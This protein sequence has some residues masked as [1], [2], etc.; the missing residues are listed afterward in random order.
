MASSATTL[1]DLSYTT[2]YPAAYNTQDN[3]AYYEQDSVILENQNSEFSCDDSFVVN[4][5]IPP[6]QQIY[7][8]LDHV[9]ANLPRDLYIERL[10]T[11]T[12]SD[13]ELVLWYRRILAD[14]ARQLDNCPRGELKG[15]K[16]TT[17][18][19]S[20]HKFATDCYILSTFI[21]GDSSEIEMVFAPS[22]LKKQN[23]TASETEMHKSATMQNDMVVMKSTLHTTITRISNLETNYNKLKR[24]IDERDK[25]LKEVLQQNQSLE[26]SIETLQN[27]KTEIENRIKILEQDI[28][29]QNKKVALNTERI[30]TL[31]QSQEKL[32]TEQSAK[33]TTYDAFK[34]QV[35]ST[36]KN[37][38]DFDPL[39]NDRRIKAIEQ[40]NLNML[41]QTNYLRKQVLSLKSYANSVSPQKNPDETNCRT[42]PSSSTV[43]I[44]VSPQS[45]NQSAYDRS[46][47]TPNEQLTNEPTNT[48]T[49]EKRNQSL[50]ANLTAQSST[51]MEPEANMEEHGNQSQLLDDLISKNLSKLK[52][53]SDSSNK[54]SSSISDST[55]GASQTS[56]VASQM[57]SRNTKEHNRDNSLHSVSQIVESS[58]T[59]TRAAPAYTSQANEY[60]KDATQHSSENTKSPSKTVVDLTSP[61]S[62]GNKTQPTNPNPSN[63][64]CGAAQ[65]KPRRNN[66]NTTSGLNRN[67]EN[68][69]KTFKGVTRKHTIRYYIGHIDKSSTYSG[70]IE[71]LEEQHLT[72]TMVYM[73]KTRNGELAARINIPADQAEVLES[74]EIPWPDGVVVNKWLSK[75][76][77]RQK[78]SSNNKRYYKQNNK[79]TDSFQADYNESSGQS[80]Q[81]ETDLR[82][83]NRRVTYGYSRY[84]SNTYDNYYDDDNNYNDNWID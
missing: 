84:E 9:L 61:N 13:C 73:F 6:N 8:N 78:R 58:E 36:V 48:K 57:A 27:E 43:T 3:Q 2:L 7:S 63:V 67:K 41:S 34:K 83:S 66:I 40:N 47:N 44:E 62:T 18:S 5:Q 1:E 4:S 77:L 22:T 52:Q 35:N 71:F 38:E 51:T 81:V 75:Y 32:A 24:E 50:F 42:D 21:Q 80:L 19:S 53:L 69:D 56:P 20:M 39:V 10:I 59:I 25:K 33:F 11:E 17:K 30:K 45:T 14:R 26:Q 65:S 49:C 46:S 55:R 70:L 15:R 28:E 72:A 76:Q 16:S 64:F 68:E 82:N 79:D 23:Q 60:S 29:E 54:Q 37:I 74:G 12:R 31:K